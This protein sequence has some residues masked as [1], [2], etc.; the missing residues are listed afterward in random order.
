MKQRHFIKFDPK[1][2]Q[3]TGCDRATLILEKVEYFFSKQPNGFY[4]FIEPCSHRLYKKFD[5]WSEELGCDRKCFTRSWEKIAFRHKSR[6]AFN[7]A[8]DKFEGKLYAHSRSAL[9]D[10]FSPIKNLLRAMLMQYSFHFWRQLLNLSVKAFLRKEIIFPSKLTC[11]LPSWT[12]AV[13]TSIIFLIIAFP[14]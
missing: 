5:S 2:K 11:P 9:K 12:M 14:A 4:K 8:I 6:R 13:Q 7:E 3:I 10:V 1:I